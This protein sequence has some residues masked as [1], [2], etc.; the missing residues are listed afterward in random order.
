MED[1]QS[2]TKERTTFDMCLNYLIQ[3]IDKKNISELKTIHDEF[4]NVP[5]SDVK[6]KLLLILGNLLLESNKAYEFKQELLDTILTIIG[7]IPTSFSKKYWKLI[8]NLVPP[9]KLETYALNFEIEQI[10]SEFNTEKITLDVLLSMFY[11]LKNNDSINRRKLLQELFIIRKDQLLRDG[12]QLL[13]NANYSSLRTEIINL[14]IRKEILNKSI[15]DLFKKNHDYDLPDMQKRSMYDEFV[16]K[17][18][19][20]NIKLAMELLSNPQFDLSKEYESESFRHL[21]NDTFE[22]IISIKT[23]E[24]EQVL[25]TIKAIFT[26]VKNIIEF[27]PK[28]GTQGTDPNNLKQLIKILKILLRFLNKI[29]EN[30][31]DHVMRNEAK[32]LEDSLKDF[33]NK[34]PIEEEKPRRWLFWNIFGN[35]E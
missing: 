26:K 35:Y 11:S 25:S 19:K 12:S 33:I 27:K 24:E 6:E 7:K 31:K 8:R 5:L 17:S 28:S 34:H 14:Y 30:S 20:I 23:I 22:N 2:Q 4:E 15:L 18:S 1:K 21:I 32:L 10:L 13:I 3:I 9:D 29:K 16:K